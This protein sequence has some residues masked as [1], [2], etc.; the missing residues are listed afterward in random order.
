[1]EEKLERYNKCYRR[2]NGVFKK[3]SRCVRGWKSNSSGNQIPDNSSE[4]NTIPYVALVEGTAAS[5]G[6]LV[7]VSRPHTGPRVGEGFSPVLNEALMQFPRIC[8]MRS[9]ATAAA[10]VF[11]HGKLKGT[12][13]S[14]EQTAKTGGDPL[15]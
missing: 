14:R 4:V 3:K 7:P 13:S 9:A 12:V 11:A 10:A 8:V 5:N 2:R 1:M 6:S 15:A